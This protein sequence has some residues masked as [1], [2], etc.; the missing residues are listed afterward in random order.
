[1]RYH[2]K[3]HSDRLVQIL[4]SPPMAGFEEFISAW[5]YRGDITAIVDTGP[6]VTSG[7][8]LAALGEIG[9]TRPDYILLTHIHI[10]HAGGAGDM[11]A[12]FPEA[13]VVCHDTALP[14]L[15][16]PEKL[17]QGTIKT[18]GETGRAYGPITAVPKDRLLDVRDFSAA[19]MIAFPTPGHAPHHVSFL[20]DDGLLFA[21]EAGGVSIDLHPTAPYL[22]PAT[23][24]K[25]FMET[26]LAS[27]DRLIEA[28]PQII[29]YGHTA[30]KTEAVTWLRRHREQLLRWQDLIAEEVGAGEEP[31]LVGRC[32][33]R[34]KNTD[35]LL[36]GLPFASPA[37]VRREDFFIQNS[38]RGF[39]G[40][41]QPRT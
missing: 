20:A 6:S 30:M 8:L 7:D 17:W 36:E 23:P 15:I 35:P 29:C 34:L 3:R 25:F 38:I 41:L 21:G 24:P 13:P 22:R 32:A 19:D 40:Y 26:S 2:I 10:D 18:L 5:V 37:A 27:I 4:L 16:D 28:R 33:E 11:A 31:G 1:M 12:A 9:L 39:V 14:H